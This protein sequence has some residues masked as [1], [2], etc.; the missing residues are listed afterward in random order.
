M[1][2]YIINILKYYQSYNFEHNLFDIEKIDIDFILY[3]R[4]DMLYYDLLTKFSLD[5]LD[6]L[7][8]RKRKIKLMNKKY[9]EIANQLSI[10]LKNKNIPHV[11]LKGI[12]CILDIYKKY[13]HRY[14]GDIDMLVDKKHIDIVEEVLTK[15]GYIFAI[16][17]NNCESL[18]PASRS[19]ILFQKTFTHEI[20][21]MSRHED[22]GW[23]S[24]VDV[25]FLFSWNGLDY[26]NY[27]SISEFNDHIINCNGINV[28]DNVVNML[29]MCCHL[30]NEAIYFAL[31]MRF[32]G[33]DPKE[34]KLNR[35]FDI[36]IL[37]ERLTEDDYYELFNLAE[38]Y[39]F[40]EKVQF[41]ITLVNYLL[42]LSI[43]N[44]FSIIK[45]GRID[46]DQ[47]ITKEKE[48][49]TWPI[50]IYE[51]VFDINK[52]QKVVKKLFPETNMLK[53]FS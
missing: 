38:K 33:G 29:H 13:W 27:V 43:A 20:H 41:S 24:N 30:Y 37:A 19:D 53:P 50:S 23:V 44:N 25:N 11:F 42:K 35:V 52:K 31:N 15:M 21:N 51:R 3:H 46:Y 39:N 34:I 10:E 48:I 40:T 1:Q 22:S 47:Y 14:F 28:F 49:A 26:S 5:Q 9:I 7:E 2:N 6:Q 12:Y 18:E 16:S 17:A 36:A 4:L 45:K 8:I 32:L